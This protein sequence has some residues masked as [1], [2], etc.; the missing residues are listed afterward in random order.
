MAAVKALVL[1]GCDPDVPN[2]LGHSASVLAQKENL[3]HVWFFFQSLLQLILSPS[4]FNL[5]R[6]PSILLQFCAAT[7]DALYEAKMRGPSSSGSEN[8]V[9]RQLAKK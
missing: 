6:P 4:L 5:L 2:L 7:Q 1:A 3:S 9:Y 8:L